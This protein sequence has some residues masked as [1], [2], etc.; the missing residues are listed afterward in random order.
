[1]KDITQL[2]KNGVWR[3]RS[4]KNTHIIN[5]PTTNQPPLDRQALIRGI[6]RP[7]VLRREKGGHCTDGMARPKRI[8]KRGVL[9]SY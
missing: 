2:T 8:S 4:R 5:P 6:A 3:E 1:M 9:K 7:A